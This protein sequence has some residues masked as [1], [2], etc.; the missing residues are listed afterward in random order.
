VQ[1]IVAKALCYK[2]FLRSVFVLF[3]C[4]WVQ[5]IVAKALCY[6]PCWPGNTLWPKTALL[7]EMAWLGGFAIFFC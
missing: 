1:Y 6:Q 5:Y 3:V 7:A 4:V 2:I